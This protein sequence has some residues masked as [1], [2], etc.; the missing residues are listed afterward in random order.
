MAGELKPDICVIGG[1]PGGIA[2]AVA[3]ANEGVPVIL[4]ERA[5]MGGT[6]LLHGA[7]PSKAF[8]SAASHYEFLRRGP[9]VGVTGAPLQVNFGKVHDHMRVVAEAVAPSVS[10]ERLTALGV[11][12]IAGAASF[13][14]KRRIIVGDVTIRPRRFVIA[15]GAVPRAP[16]IPGLDGIDYMTPETALELTRKP[17]HLLVL[18]ADAR[19]LE[20]AQAYSRLGVDT[21]VL[22][23][24]KALPDEDPEL[25]GAVLDRLRAEGVRVR[26]GVKIVG[27]GRRRG[28]VRVLINEN[29]DE[30]PVDGSHLLVATGRAPNIAGLNLDAARV[31]YDETGVTVDRL[32]RTTN[33]RVYAV[34]DVIPGP[35]SASRAVYQ[36]GHVLRA[37]LYR[38]PFREQ[39]ANVPIVIFTD[40]AFANVGLNEA[41]ARWRY[42]TIRV[43]R[44]PFVEND[45]AQAERMPAGMIKVIAST[46]GRILGAGIVGHDA[47]EL[48]ALWSLAI[49][50]RLK[51][52]DMLAFVP[53]YPSRSEISLRAAETFHGPGLTRPGR[54]RIIEFLRKFG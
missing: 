41:D 53:P 11:R 35:A 12:V 18:G 27:I 37:I 24:A 13:V 16:T 51:I 52:A 50:N 19:G 25:V 2:V 40:P 5:R 3:A 29:D 36:A 45:L 43:L 54:R 15:T 28:G 17:A 44:Y 30:V 32:L 26:D 7:V 33:R 34:G 31:A 38:L 6:N 46:R 49:A 4:V 20:L 8:L 47:G 42:E 22:D 39:S 48:I 23:N 10:A 14:D 1:G 21:T 9:A